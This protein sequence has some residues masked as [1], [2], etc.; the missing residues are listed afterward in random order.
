MARKE[1]P[2]NS[3]EA[4]NL[5]FPKKLRQLLEERKPY[6]VTQWKLAEAIGVNRQ[7]ISQWANGSTFPDVNALTKIA[8]YFHV[9]TDYLLGRAKSEQLNV[10][11]EE[12]INGLSS[13]YSDKS[14]KILDILLR[15]TQLD[16][17]LRAFAAYYEGIPDGNLLTSMGGMVNL[18][19]HFRADMEAYRRQY[20]N[21]ALGHFSEIIL[22]YLDKVRGEEHPAGEYEII[23]PS[24]VRMKVTNG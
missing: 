18:G 12:A 24:T 11:S 20:M 21:F 8:D 10:F 4:Y 7:S 2:F 1:K 22:E 3:K 19:F 13:Y 23:H 14:I 15:S 17:L 16:Y 9:S 5:P 6:G